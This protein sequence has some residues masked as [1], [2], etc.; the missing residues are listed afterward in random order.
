MVT[1]ASITRVSMSVLFIA[2]I[3]TIVIININRVRYSK[4]CYYS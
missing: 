4:Y 3:V 1:I 2:V